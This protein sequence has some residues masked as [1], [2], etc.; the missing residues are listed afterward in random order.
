MSRRDDLFS[1]PYAQDLFAVLRELERGAAPTED[2]PGKPRIGASRTAGEDVVTLSQDPH[3]EF[4]A[5]NVVGYEEPDGRPPR[6]TARFLG[7]FGPQGALPLT[8]TV[9]AHRWANLRQDPSFIHFADIFGT[10]FLQLFYRAWGMARPIVHRDRPDDD[11]FSDWLGSFAGIGSAATR[12]QP[13]AAAD[14]RLAFAGLVAPRVKSASRLAHLLRGTLKV[15]ADVEERIGTWLVF[16]PEDCMSLGRRGSALGVDALL[17]QRT[18]S[19]NDRIRIAIRTESLE[20]YEDLLPTGRRFDELT[21]LVLFYV[22]RNWT[23]EIELALPRA[24]APPVRLG[25]SG[26]LGFTSWVAPPASGDTDDPYRRDA[27]F[28]PLER[29]TAA[30]TAHRRSKAEAS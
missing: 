8:T 19:I 25:R 30:R 6:L 11:R 3:M 10:R 24:L 21:D 13:Q 7:F 2:R 1:R 17:G 12:V 27:R 18:Y 23:F 14:A 9:D 26:Q 4:A 15:D 5:S 22:G 16:E 28:D 29:R 20:Q